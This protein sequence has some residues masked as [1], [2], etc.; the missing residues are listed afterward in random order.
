MNFAGGVFINNM[1]EYYLQSVDT[2]HDLEPLMKRME[3]E[4]VWKW[5]SRET[6]EAM[7]GGKTGC[8]HTFIKLVN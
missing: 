4:G 1:T 2:L 7:L 8:F 6:E 5:I 3:N